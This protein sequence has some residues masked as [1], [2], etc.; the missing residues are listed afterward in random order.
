VASSSLCFSN[1][2]HGGLKMNIEL[3]KRATD[4]K[5][6]KWMPGMLTLSGFRIISPVT[7]SSDWRI[8]DRIANGP[9]PKKELPNLDDPATIGCMI[10][11]VREVW[12]DEMAYL[13]GRMQDRNRLWNWHVCIRFDQMPFPHQ[14]YYGGMTQAEAIIEALEDAR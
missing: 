8:T 7:E 2:S 4:C 6:F 14:L 11:L 3:A 13:G 1:F 9:E 10:E 12:K 5:H